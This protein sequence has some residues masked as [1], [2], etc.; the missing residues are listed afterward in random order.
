MK[1]RFWIL[2]IL[3]V[4]LLLPTLAFAQTISLD[5]VET[6]IRSVC[7]DIVVQLKEQGAD[8]DIVLGPNV[9]AAVTLGPIDLS[10]EKALNIVCASGGFRYVKVGVY[11]AGD[12]YVIMVADPDNP[13]FQRYA[14]RNIVYLDYV[15]ASN[16]LGLLKSYQPYLQAS[17]NNAKIMVMALPGEMMREIKLAIGGLDVKGRQVE[18]QL[19]ASEISQK[20]LNE[21]GFGFLEAVWGPGREKTGKIYGIDIGPFTFG[22][23]YQNDFQAALNLRVLYERGEATITGTPK[24]RVLEGHEAYIKLG[25]VRHIV[26]VVE[27]GTGTGFYNTYVQ[28]EE[29]TAESGM[30]AKINRVTSDGEIVFDSIQM[31]LEGILENVQSMVSGEIIRVNKRSAETTLILRNYE[32]IKVGSMT[33]EREKSLRRIPPYTSGGKELVQLDLY[34]TANVVGTPSPPE[35]VE[36]EKFVEEF[37]IEA[38]KQK[39]WISRHPILTLIIVGGIVAAVSD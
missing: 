20:S 4:L 13:I 22:A 38:P 17:E 8:V 14:A 36:L 25:E 12:Y 28:K 10:L 5:Y 6:D 9:E 27:R 34:M 35:Y 7:A 39:G 29:V 18:I 16:V 19:I 30:T 15:D 32:T 11:G 21:F 26:P 24:I 37:S 1:R 31:N 2:G 23:S 3:S 33:V